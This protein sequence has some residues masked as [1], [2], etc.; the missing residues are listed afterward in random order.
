MIFKDFINKLKAYKAYAGNEELPKQETLPLVEKISM[1]SFIDIKDL[2]IK[3]LENQIELLNKKLSQSVSITN[4]PTSIRIKKNLKIVDVIADVFSNAEKDL[5]AN[6][7]LE[8]MDKKKLKKKNP[9]IRSVRASLYYMKDI[10][11]LRLG[12]TKGTFAVNG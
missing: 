3:A 8:R 9:D 4:K 6:E 11:Y 5:N 7:V 12:T 1:D 10:D 2:R